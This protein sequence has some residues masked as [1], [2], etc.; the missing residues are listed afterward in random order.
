MNYLQTVT[1]CEFGNKFPNH[2]ISV[3]LVKYFVI[4]YAH[5]FVFEPPTL[6]LVAACIVT[7]Y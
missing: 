1:N 2:S 4:D 7:C 6:K 5:K 3:G